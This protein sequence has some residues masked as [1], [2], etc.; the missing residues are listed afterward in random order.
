MSS[1]YFTLKRR[2]NQ[3]CFLWIFSSCKKLHLRPNEWGFP[4]L[5]QTHI[6]SG[7]L[8]VITSCPA[9]SESLAESRNFTTHLNS[10]STTQNILANESCKGRLEKSTSSYCI[11]CVITGSL[12]VCVWRWSYAQFILKFEKLHC[13]VLHPVL[14]YVEIVEDLR[15]AGGG[16]GHQAFLSISHQPLAVV[17]SHVASHVLFS[18]GVQPGV[19]APVQTSVHSLVGL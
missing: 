10:G 2:C 16:A 6:C 13:S 3:E 15:V 7:S 5:W 8:K 18:P 12:F 4:T 17:L 19:E 14:V 1:F 11:V 9:S